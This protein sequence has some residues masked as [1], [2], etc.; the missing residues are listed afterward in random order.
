MLI[1]FDGISFR[2]H[3]ILPSLEVQ[4]GGK[5]MTIEVEVVDVTLD[6]HLLLGRN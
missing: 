2:S 1:Y 3:G 4:F 5:T 6:C